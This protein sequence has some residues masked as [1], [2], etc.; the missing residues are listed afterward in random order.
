VFTKEEKSSFEKQEAC[1]KEIELINSH[2]SGGVPISDFKKVQE[3]YSQNITA[4]WNY[5]SKYSKLKSARL[6]AIKEILQLSKRQA[7]E[8]KIS[9]NQVTTMWSR[10][11]QYVKE[12]YASKNEGD[13]DTILYALSSVMVD[14]EINTK[15]F[16]S[17]N[18]VAKA[19]SI[20]ACT[21]QT[22]IGPATQLYEHLRYLTADVI[23]NTSPNPPKLT[24]PRR[25]KKAKEIAP[26]EKFD[27]EVTNNNDEGDENKIIDLEDTNVGSY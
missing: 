8:F 22:E 27:G 24:I 1:F 18:L 13:L 6:K 12:C 15:Y 23:C 7:E 17:R 25:A 19:L 3:A 4:C 11:G 16:T 10:F 26:D 2:Y 5:C 9:K 21:S 14:N 20:R